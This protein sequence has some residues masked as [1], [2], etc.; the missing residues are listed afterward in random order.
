MHGRY[1]LEAYLCLVS[2]AGAARRAAAPV[3]GGDHAQ[4]V[5]GVT[6][7]DLDLVL[8]P[9]GDGFGHRQHH[10]VMVLC[11]RV[12]ARGGMGVAAG[13]TPALRWAGLGATGAAEDGDGGGA[14]ATLLLLLLLLLLVMQVVQAVDQQVRR[15]PGK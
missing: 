2:F 11:G 7:C 14:S 9:K 12:C 3:L 10:L 4:L 1:F 6:R 5:A 8:G 15:V 13:V